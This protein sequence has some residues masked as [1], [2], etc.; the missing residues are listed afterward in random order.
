MFLYFLVRQRSRINPPTDKAL[1]DLRGGQHV[2]VS[3]ISEVVQGVGRVQSRTEQHSRTV[4]PDALEGEMEAGRLGAPVALY[5][6]FWVTIQGMKHLFFNSGKGIVLSCNALL[7]GIT[8][9]SP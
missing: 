8:A 5:V 9:R 6:V 3:K 4:E 1:K 7:R 2:V